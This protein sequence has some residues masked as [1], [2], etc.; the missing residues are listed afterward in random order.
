MSWKHQIAVY[1]KLI[2]GENTLVLTGEPEVKSGRYGPVLCI[3][4]KAGV[5][6]FKLESPMAVWFRQATD[7]YGD[8]LKGLTMTIVRS[9]TGKDSRYTKKSMI[10][11]SQHLENKSTVETKLSAEQE[12]QAELDKLKEKFGKN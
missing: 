9:G 5:Y 6:Q 7:S 10:A 4:T 2:E 3:P 8:E 11:P 1:P 12:Y